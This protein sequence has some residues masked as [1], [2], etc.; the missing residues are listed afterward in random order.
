MAVPGSERLCSS[1]CPSCSKDSWAGKTRVPASTRQ[2][3]RRSTRSCPQE[4]SELYET[5][6]SLHQGKLSFSLVP[7]S[8]SG[9]IRNGV[10][11]SV[12][13]SFLPRPKQWPGVSFSLAGESREQTL[14]G[15]LE[16]TLQF[17]K[18]F[19]HYH[20]SRPQIIQCYVC[21]YIPSRR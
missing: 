2:E 12:G 3:K 7:R 1:L 8:C 11:L 10:I 21:G 4:G 16:T 5:P 17:A 6:G 20:V 9:D 14:P 19:K 15:P 18:H 13:L